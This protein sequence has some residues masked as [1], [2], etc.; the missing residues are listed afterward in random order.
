MVILMILLK[1]VQYNTSFEAQSNMSSCPCVS[2]CVS[3]LVS[4]FVTNAKNAISQEPLQTPA[5]ILTK[6][7]SL[8]EL[9]PLSIVEGVSS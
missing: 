7:T 4:P 2:C 6:L 3:G 1:P 8:T 9:N 5:P